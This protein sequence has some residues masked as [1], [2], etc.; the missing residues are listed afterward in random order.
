MYWKAGLI[1]ASQCNVASD[2]A[3]DNFLSLLCLSARLQELLF[4]SLKP[5]N[6]TFVGLQ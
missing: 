3:Q 2:R 5:L 1:S 6:L 4:F